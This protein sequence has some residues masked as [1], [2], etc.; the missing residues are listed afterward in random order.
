[1]NGYI[2]YILSKY[3]HDDVACDVKEKG[4]D[5]DND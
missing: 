5:K 1:M 2:E 4:N 3:I